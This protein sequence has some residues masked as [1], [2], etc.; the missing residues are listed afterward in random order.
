MGTVYLNG[1]YMPLEEARIPVL[2]RGFI[3]GDGVYEYIPVFERAPF[4]MH[5]HYQRLG[6]SLDAV[7]IPRPFDEAAFAAIVGKLVAAHPW[8]NQGVYVHIT[9]G[10]APRDHS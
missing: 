7:K 5:E 9:R 1:D 3:F 4:R 6:R 2:D 10:P 8:D